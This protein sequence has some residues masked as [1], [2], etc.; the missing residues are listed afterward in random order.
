MLI[1]IRVCVCVYVVCVCMCVHMCVHG[2]VITCHICVGTRGG[3]QRAFDILELEL[4]AVVNC[5]MLV[6][7]NQLGS[8]GRTARRD[9]LVKVFVVLT[10]GLGLRPKNP[11][12][13]SQPSAT[14]VA[15]NLMLSVSLGT[16]H[17]HSTH[18]QMY[19]SHQAC[20]QYTYTHVPNTFTHKIKIK[21]F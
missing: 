11:H 7:E 19:Q 10:Q 14:P 9:D 5:L 17:A 12:G 6:L 15:G 3:Q 8:S 21:I 1:F 2:C 4:Q 18:I 13:G 20:T 16:R